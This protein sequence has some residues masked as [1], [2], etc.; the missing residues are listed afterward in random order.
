MLEN[1]KIPAFV[2][3]S[4]FKLSKC[5]ENNN[6]MTLLREKK[7]EGGGLSERKYFKF[8]LNQ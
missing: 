6:K 4:N 5:L 3:F 2:L 8:K 7:C 1:L